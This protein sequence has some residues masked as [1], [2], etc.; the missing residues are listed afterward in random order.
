[1]FAIDQ[2]AARE[3][4]HHLLHNRPPHQEESLHDALRP[5]PA[6]HER[7]G[8]A[9]G[10]ALRQTRDEVGSEKSKICIARAVRNIA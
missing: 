10:Q 8:T 7:A 9:A 4:Q 5:R 1:M 3:R 6:V 2:S